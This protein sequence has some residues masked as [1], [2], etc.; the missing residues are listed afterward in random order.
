MNDESGL[1]VS[2]ASEEKA[3]RRRGPV[4]T[5]TEEQ[6]FHRCEQRKHSRIC[7]G[8]V[9]ALRDLMCRAGWSIK[10]LAGHANVSIS[11]LSDFLNVKKFFTTEC[12]FRVARAFGLLLS[13]FDKMAEARAA[14]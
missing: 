3:K 1:E 2:Q 5:L 12:L 6:V 13:R 10:A 14:A 8:Q 4:F 9:L 11:H 7:A